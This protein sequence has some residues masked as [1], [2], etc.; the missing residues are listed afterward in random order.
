MSTASLSRVSC[1][2]QA[3]EGGRAANPRAVPLSDQAL[4]TR[5]LELLIG[6]SAASA[7][8]EG[9]QREYVHV[10]PAIHVSSRWSSVSTI[11][12]S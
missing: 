3:G 6:R 5:I 2:L 7:S 4:S 10:V 8:E 12:T 11:R 1:V 9:H